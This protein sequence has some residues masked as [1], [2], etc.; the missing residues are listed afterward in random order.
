MLPKED[1][2][3]GG[4]ERKGAGADVDGIGVA[5]ASGDGL[6]PF[7]LA[8]V[9]FTARSFAAASWADKAILLPSMSSSFVTTGA[10]NPPAASEDG[11]I[12]CTWEPRG[13]IGAASLV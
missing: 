7:N 11:D 1:R 8:R 13:I 9:S 10:E 3:D 2:G 4:A 12:Y 5:L 6:A